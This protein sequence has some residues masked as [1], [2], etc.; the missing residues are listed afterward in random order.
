VHKSHADLDDV[1]WHLG[2]A[3]A[4]LGPRWVGVA[5]AEPTATETAEAPS[6][7]TGED[8][9]TPVTGPEDAAPAP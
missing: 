4:L 1:A 7:A 9:A 3:K 6:A 2:E 5:A 8:V